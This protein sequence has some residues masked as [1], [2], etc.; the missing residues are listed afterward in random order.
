MIIRSVVA[1]SITKGQ[2]RGFSVLSFLLVTKKTDLLLLTT[3]QGTAYR[4]KIVPSEAV[5]GAFNI[6]TKTSSYERAVDGQPEDSKDY[7]DGLIIRQTTLDTDDK[8]QCWFFY[9]V[10]EDVGQT[11]QTNA[12]YT[13]NGNFVSTVSDQRGNNTTYSYNQNTGTLTSVSDA[14]STTS[15]TYNTEKQSGDGSMIE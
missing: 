13:A 5:A 8:S 2:D 10:T 1:K 12:T 9:P 4:F 7:E 14:K 15:Y 3:A 11:I 6:L